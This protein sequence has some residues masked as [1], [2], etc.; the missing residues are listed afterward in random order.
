MK[1]F[2]D[3]DLKYHCK[4]S[5]KIYLGKKIISCEY[6]LYHLETGEVFRINLTQ[7][8][9]RFNSDPD[10]KKVKREVVRIS[11]EEKSLQSE[12]VMSA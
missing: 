7:L 12:N 4:E 8:R 10:N 9:K 1:Q 6:K 11:R 3:Y 2:D 5:G